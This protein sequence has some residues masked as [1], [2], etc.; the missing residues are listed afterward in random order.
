M[1]FARTQRNDPRSIVLILRLKKLYITASTDHRPSDAFLLSSSFVIKR[2]ST[3]SS[4][5]EHAVEFSTARCS[6]HV[7]GVQVVYERQ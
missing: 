7:L 6:L 5:V 1:R 3:A 2:T 4:S